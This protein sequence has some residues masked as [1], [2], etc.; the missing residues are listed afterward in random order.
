MRLSRHWY[1]QARKLV[2]LWWEYIIGSI[3]AVAWVPLVV[4]G[5]VGRKWRQDRDQNPNSSDFPVRFINLSHRTDRK[6]ETVE[7]LKKAGLSR[8]VRFEAVPNANGA[9]GCALSHLGV[10]DE[11]V[12]IDSPVA[13][14]CEDDIEFTGH[15]SELERAVEDFLSRPALGILCLAYRLRGPSFPISRFLGVANNLQTTACYLVKKSSVHE[16]MQSFSESADLLARGV[17]PSRASIDVRWKDLQFNKIV[18][19]VPRVSLA[20]Q[21]ES[22]SDIV[23]KTKFYG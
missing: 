19:C 22:F 3:R 21:R 7:Q 20:R 13:M 6:V 4:A 16:L 10:L 15:N 9:L 23:G 14:V 11:L 17:S 5:W 18:F 1:L 8:A 12:R 2:S